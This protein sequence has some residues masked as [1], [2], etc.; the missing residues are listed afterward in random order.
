MVCHE[1]VFKRIFEYVRIFEYFPLNIDI[2][3]QFVVI[4]EAKYYSNIQIF[5]PNISEYWSLKIRG[6]AGIKEVL[7][8]FLTRKILFQQKAITMVG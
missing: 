2:C 1:P 7:F 6:N 3:I 8:S 4:L 5:C